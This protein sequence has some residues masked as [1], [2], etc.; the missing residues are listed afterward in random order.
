[1]SLT[2]FNNRILYQQY[3]RRIDARAVLEHYGAE[4]CTEI[5]GEDGSVE[6]V[7]SCLLDRVEPHHAHGDENPSAACNVDKKLYVCYNYAGMDLFRFIA[8]M[9]RKG[10]LSDIVPI[11]GQFLSGATSPA[12]DVLAELNSIF[13]TKSFTADVP[14]YA[15]RVLDHWRGYHPYLA[16]RGIVPDAVALLQW[17]YDPEDNRIVIPHFWHGSLVG[18]QKRAVPD[19]PGKWEGSSVQYPKY[20]NSTH[21][22]KSETLY[23]YDL[24]DG[25]SVI[26]VESPFSVAKAWSLGIPNVVATFGSSVNNAQIEL[27]AGFPKV[28]IWFDADPAGFKGEKRLV[29]KLYRRTIVNVVD[30]D[31]DT[32]LADYATHQEVRDKLELAVPAA[33]RLAEYDLRERYG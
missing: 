10:H 18:W 29:T 22:P 9:E 4:N 31:P 12:D 5:T 33:F 25:D 19:R 20:K 21:F 26:V 17:G 32:D 6:I 28:T 2:A 16:E 14:F 3:R 23:A 7:H 8:R 30:P 24:V 13:S 15:P 27:L 1:M 11:L